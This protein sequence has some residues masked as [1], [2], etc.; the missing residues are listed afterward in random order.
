MPSSNTDTG[1]GTA[2]ATLRIGTS[3]WI[4][5]ID[6]T[7]L[8]S[9]SIQLQVDSPPLTPT[10]NRSPEIPLFGESLEVEK[11]GEWWKWIILRSNFGLWLTFLKTE[12]C[13]EPSSWIGTSIPK[14]LWQLLAN[15]KQTLQRSKGR[16][17]RLSIS[18]S[19][20]QWVQP[21]S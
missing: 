2:L 4:Q 15:E 8:S 11:A 16:W 18:G 6:F 17:P 5:A 20:M 12:Q 19:S 3:T 13:Y 9:R 21:D 14:Q 7:Q 10:F 1:E